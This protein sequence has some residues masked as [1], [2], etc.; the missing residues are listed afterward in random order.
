MNNEELHINGAVSAIVMLAAIVSTY[1]V[2][3]YYKDD[4]V[5]ADYEGVQTSLDNTASA[6][7]SL[8]AQKVALTSTIASTSPASKVKIKVKAVQ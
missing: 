8:K 5:A 7:L 3:S 1:N 6:L 4:Q 2:Y